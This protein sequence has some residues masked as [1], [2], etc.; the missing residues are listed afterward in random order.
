[1][2]EHGQPGI[3]ARDGQDE[4][5]EDSELTV[6]DDDNNRGCVMLVEGIL[7]WVEIIKLCTV[8]LGGQLKVDFVF[9]FALLLL[10]R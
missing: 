9:F 4:D 1:M 7:I 3:G 8:V 5:G 10:S 2:C 6:N